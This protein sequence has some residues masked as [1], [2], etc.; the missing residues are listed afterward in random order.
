MRSAHHHHR[1]PRP[2]QPTIALPVWCR[3]GCRHLR[4]HYRHRLPALPL[5]TWQLSPG[6]WALGRLD[7]M[8]G[9]PLAENAQNRVAGKGR[10]P[11]APEGKRP[12]AGAG[13]SRERSDS[14]YF[15][16]RPSHAENIYHLP[17]KWM[18]SDTECPTTERG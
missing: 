13:P 8:T 9:C 16:A 6:R 14:G 12:L 5:C 15:G 7:R 1:R 11:L 10:L 17:E 18:R 3:P 2:P 4:T